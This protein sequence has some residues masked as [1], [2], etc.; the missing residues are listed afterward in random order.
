MGKNG[1]MGE[2][3]KFGVAWRSM[4]GGEIGEL[5]IVWGVES[6][7]E[8]IWKQWGSVE[9]GVEKCVG[10]GV[11]EKWESVLEWEGGKKR[12]GG[13]FLV[14]KCGWRCGGKVWGV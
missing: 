8:G 9:G 2:Y 1:D 13:S 6:S 4:D 5:L 14:G 7:M 12:C 3:R 10:G 11:G